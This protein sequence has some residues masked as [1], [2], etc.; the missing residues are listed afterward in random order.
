MY[1]STSCCLLLYEYYWVFVFARVVADEQGDEAAEEAN[2][3]DE[4]KEVK[5]NKLITPGNYSLFFKTLLYY[6]F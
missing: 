5:Y 3:G 4:A 1:S 6:K 2:E